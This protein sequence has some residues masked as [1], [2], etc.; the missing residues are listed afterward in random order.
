MLQNP[1]MTLGFKKNMSTKFPL[2][3]GGGKPYPTLLFYYFL[4][5]KCVDL[6]GAAGDTDPSPFPFN[7]TK[8]SSYKVPGPDPLHNH[9]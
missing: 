9:K 1:C 4:L 7:S 3:G 6:E 8:L 2:G 5:R